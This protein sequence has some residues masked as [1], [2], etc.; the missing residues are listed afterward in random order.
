MIL[1]RN[2]SPKVWVAQVCDSSHVFFT[3]VFEL[4][5]GGGAGKE[6]DKGVL[7]EDWFLF[8][9]VKNIFTIDLVVDADFSNSLLRYLSRFSVIDKPHL[10]TPYKYPPALSF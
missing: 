3:F 7:S 8:D 2:N 6:V 10:L 1:R 5:D 9:W 4:F